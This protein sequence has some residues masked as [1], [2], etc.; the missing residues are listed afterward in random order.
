MLKAMGIIG[1]RA[2]T[3]LPTAEDATWQQHLQLFK[4]KNEIP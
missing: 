3:R 4:L 1:M 2:C